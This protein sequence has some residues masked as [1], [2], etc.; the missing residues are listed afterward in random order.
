MGTSTG[1]EGGGPPGKREEGGGGRMSA[2]EVRVWRIKTLELP[3]G[4]GMRARAPAAGRR[5]EGRRRG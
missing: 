5:V 4:A 1:E 3:C 2:Q